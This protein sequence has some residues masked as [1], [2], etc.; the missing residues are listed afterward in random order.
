MAD[1]PSFVYAPTPPGGMPKSGYQADPKAF[2]S[3]P[4][5]PGFWTRLG[6]Q[7]GVGNDGLDPGGLHA[8]KTSLGG[9]AQPDPQQGFDPE[10]YV[11]GLTAGQ[12]SGPGAQQ[13][14]QK[15]AEYIQGLPIGQAED[16]MK[17]L[18]T[19]KGGIQGT[20]IATD[21][22]NLLQGGG[23][24]GT[25]GQPGA[26]QAGFDPLGLSQA[27]STVIPQWL[28]KQNAETQQLNKAGDA[29]VRQ[30]L[31]GASPQIQQAY[32]AMLP[33]METAQTDET[34]TMANLALTTPMFNEIL[35]G[36]QA[37]NTA[38]GAA[39]QA[40]LAE[41]YTAATVGGGALPGA[42]TQAG[43]L[44]SGLQG[45]GIPAPGQA[46]TPAA[47]GGINPLQLSQYLQNQQ[48]G[49]QR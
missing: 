29:S 41:P 37:M 8:F 5:P 2:S 4:G 25:A 33:A 44:A 42:S 45:P 46:A 3:K 18:E 17:K 11:S 40:A 12:A 21:L 43:G 13:Y 20:Q 9:G 19:Q 32:S 26:G 48:L 34:R 22:Y 10:K 16:V 24:A 14:A 15:L 39:K 36:I 31:Q 6:W 30:A 27:F 23:Q 49:V 35:A 47:T 1:P 28:S 7:F 38:Y